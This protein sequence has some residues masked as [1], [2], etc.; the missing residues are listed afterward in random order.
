MCFLIA[1]WL[2]KLWSDMTGL[3]D[4][5]LCR[6]AVVP[7]ASAASRS[8]NKPNSTAGSATAPRLT[9]NHFANGNTTLRSP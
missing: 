5:E 7:R 4:V 8:R 2:K 6:F 3:A 9:S 1:Q